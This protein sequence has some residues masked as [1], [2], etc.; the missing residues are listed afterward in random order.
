MKKTYQE[1]NVEFISLV[2]QNKIMNDDN[3]D[4]VDGDIGVESAGGLF[5]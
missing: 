4:Y 5:G 1:P 3:S 2:P